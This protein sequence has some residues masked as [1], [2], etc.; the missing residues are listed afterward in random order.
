[1]NDSHNYQEGQVET[2]NNGKF[3]LE[4]RMLSE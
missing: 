2:T 1:M 3:L 4:S